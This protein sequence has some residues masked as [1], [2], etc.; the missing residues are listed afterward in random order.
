M[1]GAQ[2]VNVWLLPSGL[3]VL[4]LCGC[5]CALSP[6]PRRSESNVRVLESEPLTTLKG[7]QGAFS[8]AFSVDERWLASGAFRPPVMIWALDG[9]AA[10]CTPEGHGDAV[11]GVAFCP[12][13][14]DLVSASWDGS[15]RRWGGE[16]WRQIAIEYSPDG[17]PFCALALSPDGT[18][19]ATATDATSGDVMLWNTN[20]LQAAKTLRGHSYMVADLSFSPDGKR[21]AS[22]C[23]D[24]TAIVWDV[25]TG[26]SLAVLPHAHL[27][28]CVAFS[29]DGSLL[30]TGS[31]DESVG[32]WDLSRFEERT[33]LPGHRHGVNSVVF[34]RC[35]KYVFVGY[36]EGVHCRGHLAV[37]PA[38][39]SRNPEIFRCHSDGVIRALAL[40]PTGA[41][42]ATGS[43]GGTIRVWR[44]SDLL[45]YFP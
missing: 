20:P 42:L 16:G 35:G 25:D 3:T 33:F 17:R 34:S 38:D 9:T 8:L 43:E 28:E 13:T 22:A 36:G 45:A 23:T 37:W 30:A 5:E 1:N 19:L 7:Q 41:M 32:I 24:N 10:A 2:V 40:S 26:K 14:S 15:I 18:M 21:L 27:V 12:R 6:P 11:Y 4:L 29:P 31:A 39:G 44:V